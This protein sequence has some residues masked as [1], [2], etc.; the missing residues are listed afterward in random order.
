MRWDVWLAADWK[1]KNGCFGA[2]PLASA[3]TFMFMLIDSSF[4]VLGSLLS[5]SSFLV[6]GSFFTERGLAVDDFLTFGF[7]LGVL[8]FSSI[9]K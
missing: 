7:S 9:S 1:G 3:W 8:G 5:L 2:F 6:L 4:V